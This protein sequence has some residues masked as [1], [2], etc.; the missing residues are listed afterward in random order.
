MSY[1]LATHYH[2]IQPFRL[3][4]LSMSKKK[5]T[6]EDLQFNFASLSGMPNSVASE[7]V[8]QITL[9]LFTV[10]NT[11]QM[12]ISPDIYGRAMNG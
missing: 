12:S 7:T 9:S 4:E 6:M 1:P 10:L 8:Y 2:A 5:D 3:F 11:Q